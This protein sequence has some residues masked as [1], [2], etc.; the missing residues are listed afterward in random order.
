MAI[1]TLGQALAAGWKIKARCAH[2]RRD[3]LKSI[4][5]CGYRFDLDVET[6]VWTRGSNIELSML[7]ERMMCPKCKSRRVSLIYDV[8]ANP[9]AMR[10]AR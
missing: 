6:L 4:R 10:A 8:P 5:E 9:N 3:G 2:G 1:E 7:S